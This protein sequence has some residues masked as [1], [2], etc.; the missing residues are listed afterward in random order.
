MSCSC[1]PPPAS[2]KPRKIYNF[3]VPDVFASSHVPD[4]AQ[5][6]SVNTLRKIGKLQEYVDH[7]PSKAGKVSRRLSRRIKKALYDRQL[8]YVKVAVEAYCCLLKASEEEDCSYTF[9]YFN[10]ELVQQPDALV[11][12]TSAVQG[13]VRDLLVP[14][15]QCA[16][17]TR[18]R[19]HARRSAPCSAT[20][21]QRSGHWERSCS[22]STCASR[23]VCSP[24]HCPGQRLREHQASRSSL[25]TPASDATGPA[26]AST[27]PGPRA[28]ARAF[29]HHV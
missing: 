13:A 16:K 29:R 25:S 21:G 2:L 22:R 1:I 5:P 18:G 14:A 12:A 9:S 27:Y 7:N 28:E 19:V 11:S 3:L 20:S 26:P 24:L 17:L 10:K 15:R 8:G 6:V 4:V 23:C